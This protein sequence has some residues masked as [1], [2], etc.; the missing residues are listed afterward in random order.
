MQKASIS[1][2]Q[3]ISR[4]KYR[5]CCKR[6]GRS[7]I[8]SQPLGSLTGRYIHTET[9]KMDQQVL[10]YPHAIQRRSKSLYISWELVAAAIL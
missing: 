9:T 3:P 2:L 6:G 4:E 10:I 8:R 5:R 1:Q 7:C